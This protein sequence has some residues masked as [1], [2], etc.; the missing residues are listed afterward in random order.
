MMGETSRVL[1]VGLL[2]T[3]KEQGQKKKKRCTL[4][5][6]AKSEQCEMFEVIY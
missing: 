3:E 5:D 2:L 4:G 1:C 6:K